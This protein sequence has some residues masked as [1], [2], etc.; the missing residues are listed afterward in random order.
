MKS[1]EGIYIVALMLLVFVSL[2]IISRND[3]LADELDKEGIAKCTALAS[4]MFS[5]ALPEKGKSGTLGKPRNVT[6]IE[7]LV[8]WRAACAEKPPK[9]PGNVTALCQGEAT[10][11]TGQR[12]QVFY[13]EKIS[14]TTLHTGYYWCD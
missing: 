13:W 12:K 11:Q 6:N 3:V 7:Y 14:G 9:G 10:T 2:C 4:K 1:K 8:T 5:S